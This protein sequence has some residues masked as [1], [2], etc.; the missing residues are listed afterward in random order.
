MYFGSLV[1]LPGTLISMTLTGFA[2]ERLRSEPRYHCKGRIRGR[3]GWGQ[4]AGVTLAKNFVGKVG[5]SNV[6]WKI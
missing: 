2:A 1:E 5:K 4:G 3:S 6:C